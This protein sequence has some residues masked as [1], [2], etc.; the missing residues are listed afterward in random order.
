MRYGLWA[1]GLAVIVGGLSSGGCA[2]LVNGDTQQMSFQSSPEG[3]T[4]TIIK[5]PSTILFGTPVP[6]DSIVLGK[7][8]LMVGMQRTEYPQAVVFS[9]EGYAPMEMP[10][11]QHLSGWFFG[12]LIFGGFLG[13]TT[14]ATTGAA[15]EYAPNRFFAILSPLDATP[16][17]RGMIDQQNRVRFFILHRHDS[18]LF[19]LSMK[20]GEDLD[21]L[22]DLLHIEKANRQ[23][24]CDRLRTLARTYPDPMIFADHVLRLEVAAK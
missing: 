24:T 21:S 9:R 1:L 3:A 14:D 15:A 8:P 4:V 11:H 12:N 23:A 20:R 18:L 16:M 2:T 13:S 10:I 19:A 22:L 17:E 6:P 7:T 5:K